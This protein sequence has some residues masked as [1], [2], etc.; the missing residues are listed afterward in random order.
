MTIGEF[1]FGLQETMPLPSTEVPECDF[2]GLDGEMFFVYG[3]VDCIAAFGGGFSNLCQFCDDINRLFWDLSDIK[4][5]AGIHQIGYI[6]VDSGENVY[7]WFATWKEANEF[8]VTR[9]RNAIPAWHVNKG[10]EV[11]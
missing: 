2:C 10:E 8:V 4:N 1:Y 6:D 5:N 7:R 11:R 9:Q 3:G